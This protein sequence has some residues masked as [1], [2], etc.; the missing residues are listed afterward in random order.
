MEDR[1]T[2]RLALAVLTAALAVLAAVAT[3]C[4]DE[5][6]PPAATRGAQRASL[7][8]DW[9]PNPDHAGIYAA[10]K[11][12]FFAAAGVRVDPRVPSDPAASLKQ[13]AA[14]KADFAISYE[15]DVLIARS[16]GIPVTAV[17]ALVTGP[18]NSVLARG[19]RGIARPRD[20]E[21]KL[22]GMAGL[23]SDRPLLNTVVRADGGDPSKV[24]TRVVGFNLAPALAAG[25]VDATIGAYWNV[26]AVELRHKGIPVRVFRLERYGVPDYDELVVATSDETARTRPDLVRSFLAGLAQGQEWAVRNQEAAREHLLAANRDLDEA[27][28]PEQLRLVAPLLDPPDSPPLALDPDAWRRFAAWMRENGLLRRQ[29]DVD[30][31]VNPRFLPGD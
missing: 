14:G 11:E 4:G 18:L 3:G 6:G 8:L 24:R 13:V 22:V 1:M 7:I 10:V 30:R 21:G 17:G 31:A 28:V 2:R 15:P 20:L 27:L 5:E 29:V 9:F 23:P 12:G 16:E 25:N 26:E 19:D